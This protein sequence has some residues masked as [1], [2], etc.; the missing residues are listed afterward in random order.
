MGRYARRESSETLAQRYQDQARKQ[1]ALVCQLK[2]LQGML[3]SVEN[4]FRVL[5]ADEHFTTLLR[6]ENLDRV[7]TVLLN[8]SITRERNG[9]NCH[10]NDAS[11]TDRLLQSIRLSPTTRYELARMVPA[12]QEEF[13]RLMIASGCFTSPYVRALVGASDKALLANPKGRPRRLVMKSP[14]RDAASKEISE[15][16]GQLKVLSGLSGTHLMV[17]FVSTR[18]AQRLLGNRR[19]KGYLTKRWPGVTN[20]LENT[21]RSYLESDPFSSDPVTPKW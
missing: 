11:D 7:P 9:G 13:A 8:Q 2:R 12:R 16:A 18:Y 17:L 1:H 21:I 15:L 14:Q 4:G 6:A 3:A 10:E 5:L 20:G 19:V